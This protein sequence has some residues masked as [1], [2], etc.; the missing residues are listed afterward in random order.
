MKIVIRADGGREIG[1]G[2]IMRTLVLAK[3]LE[4][5]N[6]VLYV[7]AYDINDVSKYES[8]ISK[9]KEN[10][11]SVVKINN[12]NINYGLIEVQNKINA[13]VLIT[14]SYNVDEDYF[15]LMNKYFKFTGYIDDVNACKINV[16]FLINQNINAKYL[17]Y[18][19]VSKVNRKLFLGTDYCMLREEFQNKRRN[20]I[21]EKV[22]NVL[23]T[24][25]GSDNSQLT[26]DIIN[27]IS[28]CDLKFNVVIGSA[29]TEELVRKLE[30]ISK[31]YKNINL[32]RNANMSLL[33]N[34]SD[35]AISACGST[36]YELSAI[37]VPTIGITL[38]ENQLALAQTM[39]SK[40]LIILANKGICRCKDDI[41]NL[42]NKFR[43]LF[44]NYNERLSIIEN[45]KCINSNG[46]S[47]L[48][49]E[50]NNIIRG[51]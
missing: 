12:N 45:Q 38:A 1:M 2:H 8:G 42:K 27:E 49:N 36:L 41:N 25:G 44:D 3:K 50:I 23:I 40:G 15:D 34:D 5:D 51:K 17:K 10:G 30:D 29:F 47:I 24:V 39:E 26:I 32:C 19:T 4:Y 14:D 6:E 43:N 48:A 16:D 18:K 11:F 33:M 20:K 7:C 22:N 35:I 37:G 13:D 21:S 28:F 31:K 9:I 46:A